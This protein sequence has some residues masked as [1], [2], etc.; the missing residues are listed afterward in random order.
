MRW[1]ACFCSSNRTNSQ[2]STA[3]ILKVILYQKKVSLSMTAKNIALQY[4]LATSLLQTLI[5]GSWVTIIDN[6]HCK[7]YC[8]I[9]PYKYMTMYMY[10]YPAKSQSLMG[11]CMAGEHSRGMGTSQFIL[12]TSRLV[13]SVHMA[14]A[15]SEG[16]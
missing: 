2:K 14:M 16:G 11:L 9:S 1:R 6:F 5:F 10:T 15:S 13:T 12:S 3:Y 7:N 4:K 8:Y